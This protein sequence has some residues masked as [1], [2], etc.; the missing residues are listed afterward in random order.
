MIFNKSSKYVEINLHSSR[1][2]SNIHK[3]NI[4]YGSAP[5]SFVSSASNVDE[6][7]RDDEERDWVLGK[8]FRICMDNNG[9]RY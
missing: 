7:Y 2:D 6:Q 8:V 4:I 9:P 1:R 3:K 5:A